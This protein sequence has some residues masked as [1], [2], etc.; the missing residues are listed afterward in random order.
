MTET[1]FNAYEAL[2]IA[3]EMER[4]GMAFYEALAGAAK[5]EAVRKLTLDLAEQEKDHIRRFQEMI[6]A[7]C[8]D[9][10][11]SVDDLRLID[12][13]IKESVTREIFPGKAAAAKIAEYVSD[14]GE[15]LS[16]AIHMERMAVIYY[17][18]LRDA[19]TYDTGK[20]AF[21]QLVKE[22]E[23]HESDLEEA[24]KRLQLT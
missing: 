4:D 20:E 24:R 10:A 1:V 8:F 23:R 18:K 14:L 21:A 2:R 22:E 13:Y 11:W 7:E 6:D 17:R 9:D 15:A 5:D 16:L 19:C 12:D 3:T